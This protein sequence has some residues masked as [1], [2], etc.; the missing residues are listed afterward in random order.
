ME[1][2]SGGT[3]GVKRIKMDCSTPLWERRENSEVILEVSP[4]TSRK[5]SIQIM[6][7]GLNNSGNNS[8]EEDFVLVETQIAGLSPELKRLLVQPRNEDEYQEM[9][10]LLRATLNLTRAAWLKGLLDGGEDESIL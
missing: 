3:A 8:V 4:I 7:T 10:Q 2:E 6:P 5:E 1:E 9:K